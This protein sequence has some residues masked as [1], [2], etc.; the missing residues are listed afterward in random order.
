M[1]TSLLGRFTSSIGLADGNA[2]PGIDDRRKRRDPAAV[3]AVTDAALTALGG[4]AEGDRRLRIGGV[5]A[6]DLIA[7]HGSP[8]YAFD[9]DCLRRRLAAVRDALGPRVAV[10]YALK[11]NPSLAVAAVLR[12]AGAGGE[13]ASAGEVLIARRA[14]IAGVDIHFAGPGKAAHDLDAAI[15]A[16]V[17]CLNLESPAEYETVADHARRHPDHRIGVAIRVN[18]RAAVAS[19]RMRMAG[20][21]KKF[22][23]DADACAALVERILSDG[24]VDLRGLHV[25]AGTQCFDADAWLANA[26]GLIALATDLETEC[27]TRFQQLNFGGGFGVPV[28]AGDTEF[29]LE[30]AGEGVRAL[31][32][33]DARP[34]RR[35]HVELGRYL[36]ANAGVYLTRVT[37]LKESCGKQHAVLD[38][39][40]HHHAAAAGLGAVLPRSFPIVACDALP[41]ADAE[42]TTPVTIGG[43]LCTPA[44]QL[45]ADIDLPPLAPG[46]ALAVL[47]SGAYGL[48]FSNTMF[49]SHPTPAEVLIDQG[50]VHT[51]RAAGRPEDSLRGQHLPDHLDAAP[52]G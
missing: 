31:I 12:A 10:L 14:G 28:F 24:T 5:L 30:R 7:Q 13:V 36:V 29:D 51:A 39:G 19:S 33:R 17:G 50:T 25:Y 20:G 2:M 44:D 48:T 42:T 18:P 52:P 22:G 3:I 49:L 34:D 45:A 23:V 9:A 15:A 26:E 40:M 46:D 1:L 35:Y 21:S 11:A 37:Y 4:A 16:G 47:V 38:G 8:L 6:V 43:P 32:D 27:K 41:G